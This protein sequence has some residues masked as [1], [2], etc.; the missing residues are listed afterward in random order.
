MKRDIRVDYLRVL[1]IMLVIIMHVIGNTINTFGLEGSAKNVYEIICYLSYIAIPTFI[2]LSGAMLLNK[3]RDYKQ[4]FHSY[5]LKTLIALIV[6]G[7]IYSAIEIIFTTHTFKINDIFLC[8]KNIFTGNLW[9]HMWYLYFLLGLYLVTPIIC[10]ITLNTPKKT[11]ITFLIILF[12]FSFTLPEIS[13]L[14]NINIGFN[15]LF[16]S[17]FLFYFIYGFYIYHH[18][19]SNIYKY[20]SYLLGIFSCMIIIYLVYNNKHMELISYTSSLVFFLANSIILLVLG[21]KNK[22]NNFTKVITSVSKCSFGIYITHQIYINFIYKLF[23]LDIILSY[24]Y[25]GLIIYSLVILL[26]SYIIVLFSK[27]IKLIDKYLL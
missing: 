25:L 19:V 2:I 21:L 9:A 24:P 26:I 4:V 6:F 3:K 11:L 5:I 8:F 16:T 7:F 27:K 23:K 15:L 1:A 17:S 20:F 13:N 22:E 18:K 12:L 10:E 14:L